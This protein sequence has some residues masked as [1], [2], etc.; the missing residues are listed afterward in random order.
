MNHRE[1]NELLKYSSQNTNKIKLK[2]NTILL[3]FESPKNEE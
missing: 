1:L 3:K 2:K